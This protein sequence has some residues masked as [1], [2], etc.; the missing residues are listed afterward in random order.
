MIHKIDW[1]SH[2]QQVIFKKL[3]QKPQNTWYDERSGKNQR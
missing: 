3:Q 2:F 1:P